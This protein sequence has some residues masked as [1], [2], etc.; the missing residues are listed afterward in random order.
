MKC[1]Q[2]IN[3]IVAFRSD[4]NANGSISPHTTGQ[5]FTFRYCTQCAGEYTGEEPAI[6][7]ALVAESVV[8]ARV[9]LDDREYSDA[10]TIK[11]LSDDA[12]AR[13]AA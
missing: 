1:H 11:E 7:G 10:K 3:A 8:E 9:W 2:T 13:G 6:A 4:E 5:L 12:E